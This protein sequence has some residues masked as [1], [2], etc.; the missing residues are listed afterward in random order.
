MAGLSTPAGTGCV[1]WPRRTLPMAGTL[2][3]ATTRTPPRCHA[4]TDL[5]LG[6]ST[7]ASIDGD[8]VGPAVAAEDVFG[9]TCL[10]PA[11]GPTIRKPGDLQ[12]SRLALMHG[13]V[14]TCDCVA[15]LQALGDDYDRRLTTRT[16]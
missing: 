3:P 13:P 12:P 4:A 16:K 8:I 11:T 15:A 6:V 14:F 5:R 1:T 10:T 2:A 7:L 9:S